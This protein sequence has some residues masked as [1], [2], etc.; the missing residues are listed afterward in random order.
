MKI[1]KVQKSQN[2]VESENELEDS[3]FSILKITTK[4]LQS[5]QYSAGIRIDILSHLKES[6]VYK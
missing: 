2:N 5:R 3:Y 6:G 1:Q 4:L